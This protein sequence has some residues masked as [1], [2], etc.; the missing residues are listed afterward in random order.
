MTYWLYK[1]KY[2]HFKYTQYQFLYFED[3]ILKVWDA[4]VNVY[5]LTYKIVD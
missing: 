2:D 5:I 1:V 3:D 4:G